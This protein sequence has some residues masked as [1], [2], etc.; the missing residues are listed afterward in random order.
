MEHFRYCICIHLILPAN[1]GNGT[2]SSPGYPRFQ[3]CP[4]V[5][6]VGRGTRMSFSR[7]LTCEAWGLGLSLPGT[8]VPG[9]GL[10]KLTYLLCNMGI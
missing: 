10:T 7:G 9:S 8:L 3:A 4:S 2:A 5:I 6:A 1:L